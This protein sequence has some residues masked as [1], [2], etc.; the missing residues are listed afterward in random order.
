MKRILL[1]LS[2]G[3]LLV[4]AAS[5]AA[6]ETDGATD[7]YSVWLGAHYTDFADYNKKVGEYRLLSDNVFPEFKFEYYSRN[8][9]GTFDLSGH[10]FDYDNA[11]GRMHT[12]VGD[13]FKADVRYRSMTRQLGQDLLQNIE[14]R[15]WLGTKPGG[16]FLTHDLADSGADYSI[17]RQDIRSNAELL[18]S[19]KN[20]VRMLVAHRFIREEGEKQSIANS[21]CFSC[22]LTSETMPVDKRTH[23][24]SAGIEA[25]VNKYDVG[26]TFGYRKFESH[27]PD[28]YAAYDDALHPVKGTAGAEFS[29][30]LIFD[31]E[32]MPVGVLPET[33]KL[34][35]KMKIKG[36][37]GRGRFAG[38]FFYNT[39]KNK[40][41]N[42]T[43]IQLESKAYGGN[44]NYT[45]ALNKKIRLIAKLS[46][47]R[48]KNDN[49]AIDLPVFR[50]GR[51]G[52]TANFDSTR[53]SILDRK[54]IKGS[55]E[56]ITRYNKKIT[57]AVKAGYDYVL[58]YDYPEQE[59]DY[60]TRKIFG[61]FKVKFREGL[62]YSVQA[63][64][65]FEKISDP[66]TSGRGLFEKRG[67]EILTRDL[68]G[69]AFIFYHERED[70]RYQD[71]SALPT[72]RH[73]FDIKSTVR[74]GRNAN[75]MFGIKGSIDKNG[76]LDSL[77]VEHLSYQ[78]NLNLTLT[79]DPRISLTAGYSYQYYK[80]RGPVTVALFDG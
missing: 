42:Y 2:V 37:L 61:Q 71:I 67:R 36:D 32:S 75:V 16:K 15:E 47:N 59:A 7:S 13:Q 64:Y 35:H 65:R 1:F 63:R 79:P 27:A 62:R 55:G 39:T 66:F 5:A 4:F 68:P 14:A 58:R 29:S 72:D 26:Y 57:F 74:A 21:H 10:Y 18:L 51:P 80:S 40:N 24:L 78:P 46:G 34:S 22:H 8:E 76:D 60:T 11:E 77:D 12:V 38:A 73:E 20:N 6:T 30:R 41:D 53:Y 33:E 45:T 9:N 19:R 43:G 50:D 28:Q 25:E 56:I 31:G 3:L 49:V 54:T 70:L 69:F 52:V 48:V 44:F 23:Q 17:H